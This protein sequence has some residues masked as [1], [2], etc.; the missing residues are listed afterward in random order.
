MAEFA[1]DAAVTRAE[2]PAFFLVMTI[3]MATIIFVGFGITYLQP[4]A[5]GTLGPLAPV[6]HIH[7]SFYFSWM[8]LLVVQAVLVKQGNVAL[9]RSLGLLGIA[10]ATGLMIFGTMVTLLFAGRQI[11][12]SDPTAY[13]LAYLS[14]ASIVVF[15][16]LFVLAIRNIRRP[17][18]HRRLILLATMAF[19][20]AGIN[21]IFAFLFDLQFAYLALY[22]TV[23]L[24]IVALL[25]YDWRTLGKLHAATVTGALVNIVPQLL[26][27]PISSSA[28]FVSF[29][30][31]LASLGHYG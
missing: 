1:V 27:V 5:T 14:L 4:M 19:L 3:V 2:R 8:V 31:W 15:G 7:G 16:T 23:D 18:A 17:E 22:L 13:P 24:L 6:V 29:T 28:A 12:D 30:H 10:I 25:V 21:R 20:T 11:A 9:H 26:H